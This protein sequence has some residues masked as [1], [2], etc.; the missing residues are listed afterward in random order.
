MAFGGVLVFGVLFNIIFVILCGMVLVGLLL[1]LIS[2]FFSVRCIFRKIHGVPV[3]KRRR[4]IAVVCALV[5]LS[6]FVIPTLTYFALKPDDVIV[7]TPHGNVVFP[8]TTI[9]QFGW[10]LHGDDLERAKEL[11]E[12]YP[13]LIYYTSEDMNPLE[14]AIEA[15]SNSVSAYLLEHYYKDQ[16]TGGWTMNCNEK[17]YQELAALLEDFGITSISKDSLEALEQQWNEFPPEVLDSMNKMALLLTEVSMGR[18]DFRA[19]TWTPTSNAVY[20]FDMEALDSG[21]MYEI[22]FQGISSIAGNQLQITEV[23]QEDGEGDYGRKVYF[24]LDGVEHCFQ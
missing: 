12:Q 24:T 11:L 20:S 9:N 19:G 8:E 14:I 23:R 22:L 17:T 16:Q 15:G 3:P 18:Y 13:E 2:V 21:N 4:V 10:A 5:G 6:C 1:L 7:E